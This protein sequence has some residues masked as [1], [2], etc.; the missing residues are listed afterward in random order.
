MCRYAMSVYKPHFACFGC[1]KSFKRRLLLEV[2]EARKESAAAKCPDCGELM[3]N[4][5]KD[6]EAPAKRDEQAWRHLRLLYSVGIAFHS[7]GCS[8]PGYVPANAQQLADH[9]AARHADYVA[10][11]RFWLTKAAPQTKRELADDRQKHS[12]YYGQVFHL[13]SQKGEVEAEQAV[14]YWRTRLYEL[15]Q[16]LHKARAAVG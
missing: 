6:F 2:D 12:S 11:L 3:A 1:R 9:L 13:T 4:M 7:C 10:N 15:E 5:G 16:Y 8:G 14:A